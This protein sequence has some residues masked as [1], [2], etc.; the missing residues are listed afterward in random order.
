MSDPNV[1]RESAAYPDLVHARKA[2]EDAVA[3]VPVAKRAYDEAVAEAFREAMLPYW[4][5]FLELESMHLSARLALVEACA[6]GAKEMKEY[7][8]AKAR[9]AFGAVPE[10]SKARDKLLARIQR[11]GVLMD[12]K[13]FK[14]FSTALI[15]TLAEM[16]IICAHQGFSRSFPRPE[17]PPAQ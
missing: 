17:L 6:P 8:D 15:T 16:P 5:E 11:D 9:K 12:G 7:R 10:I 4:E 14:E 2:H 13:L 1:F 3:A